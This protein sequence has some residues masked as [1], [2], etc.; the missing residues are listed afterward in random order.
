[1]KTQANLTKLLAALVALTIAAIGVCFVPNA[2]AQ[3][4]AAKKAAQNTHKTAQQKKA[5]QAQKAKVSRSTVKAKQRKKAKPVAYERPSVGQMAGLDRVHDPLDLRSNVALVMDQETQ[6]ILV[7]KNTHAILPIASL[8]KL[9]TALVVADANLNPDELIAISPDDVDTEKGSTSRLRIG[10]LLTRDELLH[11]ALMSS[12]NR[13]AH[14][15]GRTFPGGIHHFVEL[16]N[17][18]AQQLGMRN[19]RFVEPTGLSSLNRSTAPDLAKLVSASMA[20]PVVR[21]YSTSSGL[22]VAVGNRHE[23]YNN[24]NRLVLNPNWDIGLQKT[25]FI[26]EAG[27]CLVMQAR[28]AGRQLVMVFLDSAGKFSRLGDAERVK[29]WLESQPNV[30]TSKI[31]SNNGI[32]K[33]ADA[34]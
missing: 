9:M 5:S 3:T 15:L 17:A 11:L 30:R 26:S 6:E 23:Q 34:L 12:E 16:M 2:A 31:L 14:A 1:M 22:E 18:K 33:T 29:R 27:R 13:A 20:Y 4:T 28:V 19:T 8:T 21:D 10:T 24:T 25:G 32:A 7:N